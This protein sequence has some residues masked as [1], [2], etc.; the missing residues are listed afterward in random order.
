MVL[1]PGTD[2]DCFN[3]GRVAG[4]KCYACRWVYQNSFGDIPKSVIGYNKLCLLDW[5]GVTLAGSQ[6]KMAT[7]LFD[8]IKEM[9]GKEH[10]TV[11]G[12]GIKTSVLYVAL[13]NGAMSHF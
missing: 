5:L 12:K 7:I 11:L 9:G 4:K 8:L 10:V 1:D 2:T 6:E 3:L 13:I